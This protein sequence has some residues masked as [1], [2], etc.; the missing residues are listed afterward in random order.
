M[1]LSIREIEPIFAQILAGRYPESANV[2]MAVTLPVRAVT[3][4]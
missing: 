2:A 4:V 3:T 1:A